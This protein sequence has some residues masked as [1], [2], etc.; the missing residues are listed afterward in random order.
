MNMVMSPCV[1]CHEKFRCPERRNWNRIF[2]LISIEGAPLLCL[3]SLYGA[4]DSVAFTKRV[5]GINRVVIGGVRLE[6]VNAHS[7]NRIRM[8]LVQP[9]VRFCR[10]SQVFGISAI[11]HEAEM[12]VRPSR[13]WVSRE[14]RNATDGR[15]ARW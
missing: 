7:E 10:P 13:N 5:R 6:T 11:V 4:G 14:R 15:G 9:D 2:I 8:A 3:E 12:F 1:C